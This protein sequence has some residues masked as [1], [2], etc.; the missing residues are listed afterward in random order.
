MILFY[1]VLFY[2]MIFTSIK[3]NVYFRTESLRRMRRFYPVLRHY[4]SSPH[5]FMLPTRLHFPP[6]VWVRLMWPPEGW[7]RSSGWWV[8][9]EWWWVCGLLGGE[10]V[11]SLVMSMCSMWWLSVLS[12]VIST[13]YIGQ[14]VSV[15]LGEEYVSPVVV[16]MYDECVDL[17]DEC[18]HQGWILFPPEW[19][20]YSP[21]WLVCI[22]E[23]VLQGRKC[24]L[25]GDEW[26]Q[27]SEYIL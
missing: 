6:G 16:S 10:Y 25:Q 20:S 15:P 2:F 17:G 19:W 13:C 9:V 4:L 5:L 3:G 22:L 24:V 11:F 21:G 7:V 8:C 27:V 26:V 1:F 18:V 23:H 12:W 14:W